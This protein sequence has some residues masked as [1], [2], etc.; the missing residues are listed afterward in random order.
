M[1][2]KMSQKSKGIFV[3]MGMYRMLWKKLARRELEEKALFEEFL[4]V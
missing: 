1:V 3:S 2:A 4:L